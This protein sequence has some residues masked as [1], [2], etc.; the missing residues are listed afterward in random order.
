MAGK[1]RNGTINKVSHPATDDLLRDNDSLDVTA[2]PLEKCAL[3]LTYW[4]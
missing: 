1:Q 4:K 3:D 2:P